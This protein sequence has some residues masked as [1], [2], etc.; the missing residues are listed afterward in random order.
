MELRLQIA[1]AILNRIPS[2]KVG[3]VLY[4][5]I[6]INGSPQMLKGRLRLF[7]ESLFFDY[8]DRSPEDESAVKEWHDAFRE[9]NP[10]FSGLESGLERMLEDIK[11]QRFV[12]PENS[13]VDLSRFFSLKYLIP[14]HIY[15]ARKLNGPI[16]IEPGGPDEIIAFSD[17]AGTFGT[18]TENLSLHHV[19]TETKDALQLVFFRPSLSTEEARRLLESLTKMFAQIHGGEH[20]SAVFFLR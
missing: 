17:D 6:E 5:D 20:I 19:G 7:Q 2:F 14:V 4:Q 11:E 1:P 10:S 12:E 15:D 16:K 18:I 8:A 13:A 9:L 3:A